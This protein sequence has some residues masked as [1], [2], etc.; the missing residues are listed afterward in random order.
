MEGKENYV[1]MLFKLAAH[2]QDKQSFYTLSF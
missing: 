1:Q 2:L